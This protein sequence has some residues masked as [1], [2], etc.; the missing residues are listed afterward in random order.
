MPSPTARQSHLDTA[1]TNVSIAYSNAEYIFDQI[2]PIVPVM[3]QSNKFFVFPKASWFR[4]ETGV[5]APGTRAQRAEYTLSTSSYLAIEKAVAKQVPDEVMENSDDPL[6]PLV[7][8]TEF[9]SDQILK[10]MEADVL[11][12]V[13]GSGWASS[14]TPS[15]LWSASNA[16]PL[17]DIETGILTV[18]QA[19]GRR[20]NIAVVGACAWGKLRFH[21][22]LSGLFGGAQRGNPA[23]PISEQQLADIIGV[24]KVLVSYA[25]QDSA[26]E[27]AAVSQTFISGTHMFLGYVTPN[28]ALDSPTAGYTFIWKNR[29]INRYREDQEHAEVVEA[30]ASWDNKVTANDAGYLLKSVA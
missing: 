6:R 10:S 4:D 18:A 24:N 7:R 8:A 27:G 12:N 14:A 9:V 23:A 15:V 29:E 16:C 13:F 17:G 26:N 3:K 25:V 11:G 5:R 2:F 19:I 20:P 1:L 22:Q 30:R 28:P 21:P